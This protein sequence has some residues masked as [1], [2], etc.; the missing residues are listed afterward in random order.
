MPNGNF[1]TTWEKS[2]NYLLIRLFKV[3]FILGL[4]KRQ[5]LLGFI[6]LFSGLLLT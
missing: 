2:L 6:L 3:K 5:I 4:K 1:N